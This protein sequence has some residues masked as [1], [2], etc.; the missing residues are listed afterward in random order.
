MVKQILSLLFCFFL[1]AGAVGAQ[2]IPVEKM[3]K[4]PEFGSIQLSPDRKLLAALAPYN[5]RFN[6]SILDLEKRALSRLTG[7]TATD[8]DSFF[9][10]G[11]DRIIFSTGDRQG[12]EF[13]GDGGLYAVNIDGSSSRELNKPIRAR[14]GEGQRV[15]RT[16]QPAG[17]VRG[18]KDEI[19]IRSNERSA[20]TI[21][22]FQL[23]TRTGRKTLLTFDSPGK[24]QR[25]VTDK[26][27]VPRAAVTS[28][29]DK[30]K[31]AFMYR[32]DVK[33]PW[34]KLYEWDLL[35]DEITPQ[36]FD[37]NGKLYVASNAGRNTIALFEY[38][39]A[40]KK[41]GKLVY[42]DD[43]YDLTD[44]T[45]WGGGRV[46]ARFGDE[47]ADD[48]IVGISYTAEKPKTVWLDDKY[49]KV[50]AELDK[51]FPN[52]NVRFGVIEDE[53]LIRVSSDRNPGVVYM[54]DRKKPSLTELIRFSEGI[55]PE[56]LAEMQPFKFTARDGVELHGYITIPKAFVKGKPV[57]MIVHPHGGPWARDTWGYDS[58]VQF[59]ANRGFV[60]LQVNFR[61]STGYGSKILRGGYKQ[62][63]DKSQ[64]DIEDAAMWAIKEGYADKNRVGS[65]GASYGGYSMLMQL[66][67]SPEL[68]KW[69]FNYVG[70]TDMFLHQE[71]QPAQ[72]LGDFAE[73][74]KRTNGDA[75]TDRAMFERTSPTL[76]ASKIRAPVMHAYGGEDRNV[77]PSNGDAIR[78]AFEKAGLPVD[79]TFVSEEG[80]GY[81]EDKNVFMIY[82]KLD[83]FMKKNTPS[84]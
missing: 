26:D 78:K 71:T 37:K 59:M 48:Q 13:R 69:G 47:D 46:G 43:T 75:K 55:K 19:Y 25:W 61:N 4:K 1:S 63:G 35:E 65:Y 12:F 80:H 22:L 39:I 49:A 74:A 11:N 76:L 84:K 41:L 81:R 33:S 23:N 7:V 10:L 67:R 51:A 15:L 9:W 20:D 6:I 53:M 36:F 28:D 8:V 30:M 29:S 16:F 60:V 68:Y 82:N 66:A 56:E 64:D 54:F 34:Q 14:L 2:E 27:S 73:I 38:D 17:R 72:K 77:D 57:P 70:V 42:G 58:E 31:G 18:S 62:W 40:N 21:D 32:D 50:Q 24:V 5:G 45:V 3:F 83:S 44:P 79:Y 52:S